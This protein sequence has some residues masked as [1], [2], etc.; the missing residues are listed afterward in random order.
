MKLLSYIVKA[1]HT[2][3]FYGYPAHALVANWNETILGPRPLIQIPNELASST[4]LMFRT[5]RLEEYRNPS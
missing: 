2:A 1:K 5:Y 4:K 3:G